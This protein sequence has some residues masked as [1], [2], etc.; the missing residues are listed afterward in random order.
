[1]MESKMDRDARLNKESQEK[2]PGAAQ[3]QRENA[4]VKVKVT[5]GGA[6]DR[7]AAFAIVHVFQKGMPHPKGLDAVIIDHRLGTDEPFG[8]EV[9][10][11][12]VDD[13]INF[14]RGQTTKFQVEEFHEEEAAGNDAGGADQGTAGSGEQSNSTQQQASSDVPRDMQVPPPADYP[15]PPTDSPENSGDKP[16]ATA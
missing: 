7:P 16:A 12:V 10:Q 11:A 9:K 5:F 15:T 13:A 1:M 6:E 4:D 3:A 8:R 2:M 14:V